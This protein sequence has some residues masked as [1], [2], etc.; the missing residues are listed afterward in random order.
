M[1]QKVYYHEEQYP[2]NIAG[3]MLVETGI[4]K[5]LCSNN[6]V[7]GREVH[8]NISKRETYLA[9]NNRTDPCTGNCAHPLSQT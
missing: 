5:L 7:A 3:L 6:R 1:R 9:S 8:R 4:V 2:R